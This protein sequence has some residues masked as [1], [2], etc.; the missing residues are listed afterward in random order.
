M[1]DSPSAN[2]PGDASVQDQATS[3]GDSGGRDEA[4]GENAVLSGKHRVKWGEAF[5]DVDIGELVTAATELDKVKAEA[6]AAKTLAA[7]LSGAQALADKLRTVN[8]KVAQKVMELIANGPAEEPDEDDLFTMPEG[9]GKDDSSL[10]KRVA[11]HEKALEVL[12][13][14]V[15][16]QVQDSQASRLEA[17]AE[18]ALESFNGFLKDRPKLREYAKSQALLALNNGADAVKAVTE[19]VSMFDEHKKASTTPRKTQTDSPSVAR[20][21]VTRDVPPPSHQTGRGMMSGASKRALTAW[22]KANPDA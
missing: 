16:R 14:T 15:H 8:P 3:V 22:I 1:P 20:K 17:N 7:S 5:R 12:V 18:K 6:Q 13:Q 11:K 9:N 19:A 21:V 2:P 10:A 4:G